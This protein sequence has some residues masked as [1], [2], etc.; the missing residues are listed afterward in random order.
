MQGCAYMLGHPF[1][2]CIILFHKFA[3]QSEQKF[4]A[5]E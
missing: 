4:L 5:L 1:L 2:V 3:V